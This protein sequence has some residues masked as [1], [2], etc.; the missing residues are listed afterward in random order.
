MLAVMVF[1]ICLG[2]LLGLGVYA[3]IDYRDQRRHAREV[4]TIVDRFAAAAAAGRWWSMFE[5]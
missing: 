3:L 1:P 2:L 4:K 5:R